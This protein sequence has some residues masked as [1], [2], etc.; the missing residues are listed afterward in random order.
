M[1]HKWIPLDNNEAERWLRHIVLKRKTSFG[2]KTQK[3]ADTMSVLY[4][5]LLSLW[6]SNPQTFF[7]E[8][9]RLL[10]E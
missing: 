5:T 7:T 6:N 1:D 4:S 10:S 2:S 3:W 9:K 8:Y